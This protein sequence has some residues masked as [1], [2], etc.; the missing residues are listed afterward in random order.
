MNTALITGGA[1]RIGKEIALEL[2]RNG[3]SVI[4]HYRSNAVEAREVARQCLEL[5]A[6]VA[7]IVHA[8]FTHAKARSEL[9]NHAQ[10]AAQ[11]NLSLLVNCA[12]AFEYDQPSSFSPSRLDQHMATNFNTPVELTMALY[13]CCSSNSTFAHSVTLLDQKVF[14]LNPDYMSYTLAKL[15]C[16][17]S[18]R[19]LAQC[20]APNLRVNAI[21]PGLTLLSGS[22]SQNDFEAAH[23]VAALGRSSTAGDIASAVL[24]LDRAAGV[25]GQ[26]IAVDGGQHLIA[27]SRDVAFDETT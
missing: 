4:I 23:K 5:G 17:S 7:K 10:D 6:P 1:R 24:M 13:A 11:R 14:N 20:C 19:F 18:M 25:T 22:M 8:D 26:T 12:S 16:H 21:A 9:I 3:Y 27:R 2:A 15:A